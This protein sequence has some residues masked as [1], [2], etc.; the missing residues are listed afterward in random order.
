MRKA[1]AVEAVLAWFLRSV[2]F[3]PGGQPT[4]APEWPLPGGLAA[5]DPKLVEAYDLMRY[6]LPHVGQP[7]RRAA[8]EEPAPEPMRR[9]RR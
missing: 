7:Q 5:Q 3:G 1:P 8:Q 4:A 9:K 2:Q 6:E